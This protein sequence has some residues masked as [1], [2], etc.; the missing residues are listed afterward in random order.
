MQRV[1]VLQKVA[2]GGS[3]RRWDP[4]PAGMYVLGHT[5]NDAT[6]SM[7]RNAHTHLYILANLPG[8]L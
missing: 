4:C 2:A 3:C 6:R 1:L 8:L 5:P 7:N